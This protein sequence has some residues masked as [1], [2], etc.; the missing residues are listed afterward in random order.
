[1]FECN[2]FKHYQNISEE[3]YDIGVPQTFKQSVLNVI[4]VV[5]CLVSLLNRV[6]NN[7][8]LYVFCINS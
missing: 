4:H 1:M 2:L 8:H 7:D 3:I 5:P 6:V